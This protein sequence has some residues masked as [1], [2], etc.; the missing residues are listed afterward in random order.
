VSG[1]ETEAPLAF[2]VDFRSGK[3]VRARTVLDPD[4][5]LEAAGLRD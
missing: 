1:A 2:V 4:E 3:V 5:A